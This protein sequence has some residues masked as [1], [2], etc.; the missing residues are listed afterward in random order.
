[1][2]VLTSYPPKN[3][4]SK[5]SEGILINIYDILRDSGPLA[6]H[7]GKKIG[8]LITA[9]F[10]SDEKVIL[11]FK[12]LDRLTWSFVKGAISNLYESFPEEKIESSIS[13]IDISS[14]EV[15]FIEEVVET[16]K[17]FMKNPEKFKKP[18]SDE[19]LEELRQKNPDNPWLKLAGKHADDPSYDDMLAYIE[20]YRRELDAE[21]EAYYNELYGED[22]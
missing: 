12:K 18:M 3:S 1:M 21:Q 5:N 19:E 17:E 7:Q 20:E 10:N 14:E 13:L 6:E 16:K 2:N 4:I 11:S 15:E 8:W 9:A 22:K